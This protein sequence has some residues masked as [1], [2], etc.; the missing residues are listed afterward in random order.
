MPVVRD[1]R[2]YDS[3]ELVIERRGLRG[4]YNEVIQVLTGFQLHVERIRQANGSA[5]VR[6]LIDAG[7]QAVGGWEK[8]QVGGVDWVKTIHFVNGD[9]HLTSTLGVE[10]QVSGR[11]I[12]LYRDVSHLRESLVQARIDA[13]VI[14]VPTDELAPYMTGRTPSFRIAQ[15]TVKDVQAEAE[16]IR[17][18]PFDPNSYTGAALP[19]RRTNVGRA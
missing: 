11:D 3:F 9:T 12:M 7:F 6:E 8:T 15:E 4:L 16:P 1:P 18:L 19:K 14:V 10:V 17:I 13:G 2:D 5:Y